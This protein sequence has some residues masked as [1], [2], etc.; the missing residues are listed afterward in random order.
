MNRPLALAPIEDPTIAE[1]FQQAETELAAL[2]PDVN[3]R[4]FLKLA[5]IAGGGLTLAMTLGP[6]T[7]F[8]QDMEGPL[9]GL[10]AFVRVAPSGEVYIFA[11]NPEIGQGVKTSLPMI[12]AEELDAAWD[13]V[14]VEQ[15]PIDSKY[16]RQFAG[17]SLSIPM[18]W[19]AMRQAGATARAMLVEAAAQQWGVDASTLRTENS[20]VI[21][22]DGESLSYGELAEAAAKLEV[23]DAGSL[24]LKDRSEFKLLGTRVTGVDNEAIVTGKPLFGIDTRLPGMLYASYAKCPRFG[25]VAKSANLDEVKALPGIRDAFILDA[26]GS[27]AD[28]PAGVAIVGDSTWAVFQARKQLKVDWDTSEASTASWTEFSARAKELSTQDGEQVV[29]ETGDVNAAFDDA[30]S[31]TVESFYTYQFASH[32]P[33]EPQ[34]CVAWHQDGKME[35]WAP[36]Q[37]PQRSSATAMA[38]TGIP[39][40]DIKVNQTRIGGGFGRRLL[41]DYVAEVAAIAQRV[42]APVKLQWTREE[43]M[44][45]D[46][47]RP[48][49]FHSFKGAIDADGKLSAWQNHFIGFS[50]GGRPVSGGSLG[51]DEF[52]ALNVPNYKLTQTQLETGTPCYA[53]RA[54]G[55]NSF[56]WVMQS[57]MHE[58][59][60]AAGKDHRDF[61]LEVMGEPRWF[62]EG[63]TRSLNTG[64]AADVIKLATEKAGWGQSLPVGHFHGLA[65]HFSHAGHV[66]QVA[67]VSVDA[68]KKVTVHKVT[69]A[70]DVGPIVNLS[71]AE[72]QGEGGV[73]DALSTMADLEITMEN[74]VVE[75]SNYHDYRPLRMRSTPEIETHFIQSEHSPTGLG[76]PTFPP[77]A[78][79]V[80][81]AIYAATGERI[82]T[83]PF[84]KQGFTV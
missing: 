44:A 33:L 11:V 1:I 78:P 56:G 25:G 75:Q 47:Y 65:F 58:M 17:G 66:A 3:R 48:G 43:D 13:T 34:N 62:S 36:S 31:T 70:A 67:E 46:H 49:G 50:Y 14:V 72:N 40:A 83:L 73:V 52:P 15:A 35:I 39:A 2:S 74:G 18:N 5:G 16:G 22:A 20:A 80:C 19:Q 41:N 45:H 38:A 28:L 21:N 63:N 54:P 69:V 12:I 23:P 71:G 37:T 55:A 9:P 81:N 29:V 27:H 30:S 51:K 32:A 79:A 82:R 26:K 10:N 61:L 64:R 77:L 42:D 53:W 60:V 68:N 24:T 8:G 84:S 76:E 6:R 57:F 7:A 4:T 59:A